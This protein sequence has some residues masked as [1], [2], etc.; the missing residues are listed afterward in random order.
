MMF[1]LAIRIKTD[2]EFYHFL[3]NNDTIQI[4][5]TKDDQSFNKA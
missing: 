1:V 5:C 3:E 4:Y 2:H